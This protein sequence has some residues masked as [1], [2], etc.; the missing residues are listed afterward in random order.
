MAV[1]AY[2]STAASQLRSAASTLQDEIRRL[3]TDAY[4]NEQRLQAERSHAEYELVNTRAA[5]AESEQ[6]HDDGR[7]RKLQAQEKELQTTI[8]QKNSE[9][10]NQSSSAADAVQQRNEVLGKIQDLASQLESLAAS[11]RW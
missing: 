2:I 8:Q 9:T 3:Q 11:A 7:K 1:D 5:L 4:D 10:G 6:V